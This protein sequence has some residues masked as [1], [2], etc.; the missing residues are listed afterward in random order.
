M[1]IKYGSIDSKP[2]KKRAQSLIVYEDENNL[3]A[4]ALEKRLGTLA[5]QNRAPSVAKAAA[6]ELLE[7]KAP[8]E[9]NPDKRLT[10]DEARRIEQVYS[11]IFE[12]MDAVRPL[13]SSCG[14][15]LG[16]I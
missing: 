1:T 2:R 7:R 6:A 9:R 3:T 14:A 11:S 12:P 13:C 8:R 15:R 16:Q 10:A 5:F 4:E